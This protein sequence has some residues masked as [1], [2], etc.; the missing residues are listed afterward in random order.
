MRLT[1]LYAGLF[2]LLGTTVI[3]IIYLL[4]AR[5]RPSLVVPVPGPRGATATARARASRH[6]R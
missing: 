2:L 5:G 1:L 6:I 3:A 4:L